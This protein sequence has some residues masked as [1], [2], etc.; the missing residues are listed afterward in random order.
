[1]FLATASCAAPLRRLALPPSPHPW[2]APLQTIQ[3]HW[4][5]YRLRRIRQQQT[6][7]YQVRRAAL[8]TT[9]LAR[10]FSCLA[11][12]QPQPAPCMT[13]AFAQQGE[14][15]AYQRQCF[16]LSGRQQILSLAIFLP[17]A[18]TSAKATISSLA[19][20]QRDLELRRRAN[21]AFSGQTLVGDNLNVLQ[22][23]K[24]QL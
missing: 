10:A 14:A 17:Q 3:R 12:G 24:S 15:S 16:S 18:L 5:Q 9:A 19:Q 13:T 21:L 11:C 1:M 6:E 7:G 2:L 23:R 8:G 22:V 20:Q 4:R